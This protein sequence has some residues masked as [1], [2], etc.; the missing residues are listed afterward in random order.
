[1]LRTAICLLLLLP[2]LAF[3]SDN[4]TLTYNGNGTVTFE[5][6]LPSGQA[7]VELFSRQNG[8]QNLAVSIQHTESPLGNGSSLYSFTTG[9]YAE[10]DEVEYRFYHYR[11]ASPGLFSP[12]PAPSVWK[13]ATL[14]ETADYFKTE[15]GDYLIGEGDGVFT[16][17]YPQ[18]DYT[19]ARPQQTG[20]A[21]DRAHP[22]S[23]LVDIEPEYNYAT[24]QGIYVKPCASDVW[25]NI[26]DTPYAYYPSYVFESQN[27]VSYSYDI[28]Y[29]WSPAYG[30]QPN[31]TFACGGEFITINTYI[32]PQQ[33]RT[34]AKVEFAYVIEYSK[35]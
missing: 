16:S 17:I 31:A 12:G 15:D 5:I 9:A 13:I 24:F 25:V 23:L 4:S 8:I 35:Q 32:G 2:C 3:A 28:Y 27:G 22:E 20:W 21:L 7:F 11:P 30:T 19:V 10:G 26:Q 33:V 1:M 29:S 18:S 34:N 6:T 14:G